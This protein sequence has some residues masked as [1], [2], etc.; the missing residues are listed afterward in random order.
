MLV[1]SC[2][3]WMHTQGVDESPGGDEGAGAVWLVR[4]E[5]R[6]CGLLIGCEA[7]AGEAAGLVDR[8]FWSDDAAHVLSRMP[9]YVASLV[10]SAVEDYARSTGRRVVTLAVMAQARQGGEIGWE[11]EAEER[12][13]RVPAPIRAMARIELERTAAE[14]GMERVTVGLMEEVKARYFGLA[15]Q[16]A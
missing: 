2:G 9:P 12:L 6:G 7:P 5:C 4:S 15:A 8:L 10:K 1:C 3:R 16:K 13:V 11:P 14:R